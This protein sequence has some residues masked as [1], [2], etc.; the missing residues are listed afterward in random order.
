LNELSFT[1]VGE[2]PSDRA[3]IPILTWLLRILGVELPIQSAFHSRKGISLRAK[4]RQAVQ[5]YYC[6]LLFIHRD[7]DRER[8]EDR[9]DEIRAALAAAE[10]DERLPSVCVV[11]VRM[12]EAWLLIDEQAI[13]RASGNP[14]GS[15]FLDLP[16]IP[17]LERIPDPKKT[18]H[19]ALRSACGL[20][21]R[22]LRSFEPD[23]DLLANL[24]EDFRPLRRLKAFQALEEDVKE[25]ADGHGWS[26]HAAA[27]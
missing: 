20:H 24:I 3:L 10:I 11:P 15:Q 22:R 6:D 25:I 16:Q 27:P 13:R 17:R 8:R 2:G 14:G 19:G 26:T 5:L 12:T 7:A 18:L 21:G 9:K 4:I 1:L 23:V